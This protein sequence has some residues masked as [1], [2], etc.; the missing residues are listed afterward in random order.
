MPFCEV[1][2]KSVRLE[3]RQVPQTIV[4]KIKQ[5]LVPYFVVLRIGGDKRQVLCRLSMPFVGFSV[6]VMKARRATAVV[7]Q[8]KS[9]RPI[10]DAVTPHDVIHFRAIGFKHGQDHLVGQVITVG[11]SSFRD[12][13]GD[14]SNRFVIVSN[15]CS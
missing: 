6:L 3:P 8:T 11:R 9:N 13:L 12:H 7:V 10:A 4:D 15:P 14:V 1:N 5:L 2:S